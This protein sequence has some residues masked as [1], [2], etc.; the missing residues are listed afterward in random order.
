MPVPQTTRHELSACELAGA[1]PREFLLDR[2][3]Q[4]AGTVR[5]AHR[6][7]GGGRGAAAAVCGLASAKPTAVTVSAIRLRTMRS[8]FRLLDPCAT[9]A[10]ALTGSR[11]RL[12]SGDA[13]VVAVSAK[14]VGGPLSVAGAVVAAVP[15]PGLMAALAIPDDVVGVGEFHLGRLFSPNFGRRGAEAGRRDDE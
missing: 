4:E 3:G 15:T 2:K 14:G 6:T 8:S 9:R 12:R 7:V 1:L 11:P 5:V 13:G 10:D